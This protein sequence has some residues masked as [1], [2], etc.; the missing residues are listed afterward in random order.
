[1]SD[2]ERTAAEELHALAQ[3]VHATARRLGGTVYR[4][5]LE[6]LALILEAES[7]AAAG[8]RR[9][10]GTRRRSGRCARGWA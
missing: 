2:D 1:M 9:R 10:A 5:W 6:V 3:T 7:N 8:G 4:E